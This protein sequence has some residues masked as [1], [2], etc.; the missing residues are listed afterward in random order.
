[1][2]KVDERRA[3]QLKEA[4][5]KLKKAV[6][7]GDRKE[8]KKWSYRVDHIQNLQIEAK[9]RQDRKYRLLCLQHTY[10]NGSTLE[11]CTADKKLN[12]GKIVADNE[13]MALLHQAIQT[14]P[15]IDRTILIESYSYG[16]S[17]R[18]LAQEIGLSDKTVKKHLLTAAQKVKEI[19]QKTPNFVA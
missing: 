16:I 10:D 17:N 7:Q 1:M 12:T 19:L 11:D 5:K 14:L 9:Q 6:R 8:V 18:K 13:R 3:E 2:G 15:E 4:M